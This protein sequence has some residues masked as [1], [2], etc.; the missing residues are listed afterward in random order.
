MNT[1]SNR[2]EM[3]ITIERTPRTFTVDG[4]DI[5]ELGDGAEAVLAYFRGEGPRPRPQG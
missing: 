2:T 1:P 5:L 3:T 4:N